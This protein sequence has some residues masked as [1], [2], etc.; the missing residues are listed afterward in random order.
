MTVS[1]VGRRSMITGIGRTT[2]MAWEMPF[3]V[4]MFV[5]R[6]MGRDGV[7]KVAITP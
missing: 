4:W 1:N 5:A 7:T 3:R 2:V 6:L